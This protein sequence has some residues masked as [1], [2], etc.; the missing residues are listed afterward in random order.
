MLLLP[1]ILLPVDFSERT[2][3]AVLYAKSLAGRFHSD[4]TLLHV[5]EIPSYSWTAVEFGLGAQ[6]L[7]PGIEAEVNS[8]LAELAARFDNIPVRRM[9]LS[10]DPA[11]EITTYAH[12]HQISLVV[13]PTRGHGPFRQFILGSVTAKVLHD[14]ECPV[15]TGAHLAETLPIGSARFHNIMVSVDLGPQSANVLAWAS[16]LAEAYGGKLS[17]VHVL[18]CA[19]RDV[20]E[21]A[22]PGWRS[23]VMSSAFTHVERLQSE[24]GSSAKVFIEEAG[25]IPH[26]VCSAATRE[27]VDLLVIGR[28]TTVGFLGRLR[29]NAYA[30]I[31]QSPCPV[32]SV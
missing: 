14:V 31:R 12:D 32:V 20:M 27:K 7:L 17:L 3:N 29:T 8:K 10:G 4:V 1:R 24:A 28:S 19:N 13:M 15:L 23:L 6:D 21:H 30:I 25:D 2:T 26:A 5:L 16:S 9:I 11:R 22:D 18:R